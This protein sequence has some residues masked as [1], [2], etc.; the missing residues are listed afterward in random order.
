MG[1]VVGKGA[2]AAALSAVARVTLRTAGRLTGDPRAALDELNHALRR[3]GAMSLCTV[4]AI[5]LPTELPGTAEVVLA[6]HPPP[7]LLR[8]GVAEPI[9]QT[10][11]MLGAVE[12]G[13]WRPVTVELAP[14]DVLVLY[15]DG[16]LDC[17]LPGGDRFGEERLRRL[18]ERSGGDVGG[19]RRGGRRRAA[20]AAA[21]RRRRAA[22][23][24]LP[25]TARAAR[26]RDARRRGRA[27]ARAEPAR[28]PDRA[29]GGAARAGGG[30]RR[31]ALRGGRGRRA[32]RRL[33][34]RDERDPPRRRALGRRRRGRPRG[35]ARRGAAARGHRSRP[36][37]EP[38]GH[39]PRPDGGYGLHMLDR[40]ATR[41]GVSGTAPVTVWVELDR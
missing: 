10:G 36:G 24:P 30:A 6:G 16:L 19:A 35:A 7:L 21:A 25:G 31:A 4:V 13:E 8:D 28:R 12:V 40:L 18:A 37:F 27:A 34:A 2:P 41:W 5:A 3:Q 15:T 9:G 17:V 29:A 20:R 14:R 11:P 22:R 26:A 1:D 23:D 32:D 38:G 39:G 33:G